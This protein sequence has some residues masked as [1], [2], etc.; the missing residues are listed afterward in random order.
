[1]AR[2]SRRSARSQGMREAMSIAATLAHELRN[3]RRRRQVK[4]ADLA[5]AVGVSQS[6][7]SR[8]ESG[9]GARTSIETWVALGIALDRPIAIAFG[10]DVVEPVRDAGHLAAQ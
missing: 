5:D 8:L 7:I 6:A 1:M 9:A 2:R 10:R 4:Q 3:T